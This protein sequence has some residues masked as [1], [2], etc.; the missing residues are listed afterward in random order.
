MTRF[1]SIS[2]RW[3]LLGSIA[4]VIALLG[5]AAGWTVYQLR[6]QDLEYTR[7]LHGEA[8]GAAL[9]QEM[10]AGLLLQVQALKNTLTRGDDPKQFEKYT[11]EFEARANDLR[12]LRASLGQLDLEWTA[13][14]QEQIRTFDAGWAAYLAAWP[15]A[16]EAFGGPGGGRI[17]E[18]DAVMS[19]KDRDA[20]TALDGLA[21][22]L[23]ERR[24]ATRAALSAEASRVR[25]L[26]LLVLGIATAV[27]LG[28]A[29]LLARAIVGA[30]RQVAQ[31]A[32]QMAEQDVPSFVAMARALAAGD[33]T[34]EVVVTARPVTVH[35]TDE[36]GTMAT[37]FNRI[38]GGIQEA[39]TAFA[40]MQANLQQTI[41]EVKSSA[42]VV[43]ETASLLGQVAN[44]TS[45]AVQQVTGAIQSV[46]AGAHETSGA[47][48]DSSAS[49]DQL[50]Q[51]VDGVAQGASEQARQLQTIAATA[52]QMAAGVEQVAANAQNVAAASEQARA[53]AEH[54]ARAV[55]ET[56]DGMA[57]IKQVVSDAA[58]RVE[59]LGKLSEKIGA[60]VE[61]I[62][63]IAE[64]TN[65]LALNAAIEAARAGEHGRGFAVVADEV[66]KLAER[67]Q[68]ETRAISELIRSVQ[69]GTREAVRAMEIGSERVEAGASRADQA[70]TALHAILVAVTSSTASIVE[71]AAT[72][73]QMS[74][75]TRSV[76]TAIDE[77]SAVV[78][79]SSAATEEMAAQ[80]GQVSSAIRS[81]ATLSEQSS[82][83][84][85]EVSASAEEM[86]AQVEELTAQANELSTTAERLR[87]LVL[88]FRLDVDAEESDTTP[89]HSRGAGQRPHELRTRPERPR[90]VQVERAS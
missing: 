90:I 83:A 52:T 50:A 73:R 2:L 69:S 62:D 67:S 38:V 88:R 39:G 76:V 68:R 36:I 34:R 43:S 58:A 20:V 59:E 14:E 4:L 51:V 24:D 10:R 64:Q 18:A 60:V 28:I 6:Q 87:G 16:K 29:L 31:V 12:T 13:G 81:I 53:S 40:E 25:S 56:V 86:S 35:S 15:Q 32:T 19:G 84:T 44:Q 11:G 82:A 48:Q 33:L 30:A 80:A 3:K 89:D 37:A 1:W 42:D 7:L 22:R 57:E 61:T 63:D 79:E 66:R 9:A 78:E 45:S 5:G 71:I 26:V 41:G 55:G 65:L 46:A 85:E 8:E 27:G 23:L 75:G 21:D 54:G 74:S 17:H 77:I 49:V 72:A 70:G 47:A